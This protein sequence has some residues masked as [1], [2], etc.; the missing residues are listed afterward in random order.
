MTATPLRPAG[1]TRL[2]AVAWLT[3]SSGVLV[4]HAARAQTT[5]TTTNRTSTGAITIPSFNQ[6]TGLL[7]M[8]ELNRTLNGGTTTGTLS[9]SHSVFGPPTPNQNTSSS[10]VHAHSFSF[11]S[12]SQTGLSFPS[13]F[14]G[15]TTAGGHSHFYS[16]G[17]FTSSDGGHSHFTAG[18]T[19]PTQT[20][21]QGAMAP[22]LGSTF[23]ISTPTVG[24]SSDGNHTH[25]MAGGGTNP[26]GT[27]NHGVTPTWTTV[28]HFH[29]VPSSATLTQSITL[30]HS[31]SIHG[32]DLSGATVSMQGHSLTVGDAGLAGTSGGI[33]TG[34]GTLTLN[35]SGET[36]F[37]GTITGQG[38]L[39][40]AGAGRINLTGSFA[41]ADTFDTTVSAGMLQL[42]KESGFTAVGNTTVAGGTL[43]LGN[44][45]QIAD[46]AAVTVNSGMFDLFGQTETIG[47]LAGAGG[48]VTS[49]FG[50]PTLTVGANENHATYAGTISESLA[51]TKTGS[52]AFT[53]GGSAANTY[54]GTTTVSAGTLVLDK[55]ANVDAFGGDLTV[56]GG[57]VT[58]VAGNQMPFGATP[59]P[60][61]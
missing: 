53:L 20:Y 13:I 37:A 59:R 51:L 47:A 28:T 2:V 3:V 48:I 22:F 12:Y 36:T 23:S 17:S 10:G 14:Q 5:A 46:A 40:M 16:G 27:H 25:A 26:A 56:T 38:S 6:S 42:G 50:A 7:T 35:Q 32:I 61:R 15:T 19:D 41:N 31:G 39:V 1:G 34:T 29:Y 8:V 58:T 49:S 44:T 30:W 4:G 54:S 11:P 52:G 45:H 9:H 33:V 18:Q 43:R 24:T 57:N 21:V 55:P 60:I